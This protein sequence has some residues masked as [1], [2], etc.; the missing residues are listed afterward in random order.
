VHAVAL[1]PHAFFFF[2]IAKPIISLF[3]VVGKFHFTSSVNGPECI[4]HVVSMA[5]H[6]FLSEFEFKCEKALALKGTVARDFQP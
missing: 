1:N 3:E 6:E 4:V 5:Q 2:G